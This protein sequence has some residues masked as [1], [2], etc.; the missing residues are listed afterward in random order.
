MDLKDYLVILKRNLLLIVVVL[1]LFCLGGY[2][3]T[4]RQPVSNQASSTLE[5]QRY[6]TQ[7][8]SDVNYFQYGNFYGEQVSSAISD[9]LSGWLSSPSTVAE[10][11][12]QA[13]YALPNT[14]LKNLAKIFTAKKT[15]SSSAVLNVSYSD[16]DK[17]KARKLTETATRVLKAKAEDS[18]KIGTSYVTVQIGTPVIVE[19]PKAYGLNI[20]I[21]AFFG[22][23]I[24]LIIVSIREAL[25][26]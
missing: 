23:V 14:S 6:E 3:A 1:L 10:I 9:N 16:S 17:E 8:Q 13:G 2:F 26:K 5:V 11:F 21:S 20:A 18:N 25:R 7:K 12:N 22:L 4:Y 15:I 19:A 24:S